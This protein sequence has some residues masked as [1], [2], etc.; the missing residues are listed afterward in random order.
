MTAVTVQKVLGRGTTGLSE[1]KLALIVGSGFG[2]RIEC[3]L[4]SQQFYHHE[5]IPG[6]FPF[7]AIIEKDEGRISM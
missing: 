1:V 3:R 6:R 2:C 7:M 5:S 4:L